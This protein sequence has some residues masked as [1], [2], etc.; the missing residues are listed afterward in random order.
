MNRT[1]VKSVQLILMLTHWTDCLQVWAEPW[2][3]HKQI[4]DSFDI[5]ICKVVGVLLHDIQSL[6]LDTWTQEVVQWYTINLNLHMVGR[7]QTMM[8]Q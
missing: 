8:Y 2:I 3:L 7:L 5:G 6:R 4:V 1:C